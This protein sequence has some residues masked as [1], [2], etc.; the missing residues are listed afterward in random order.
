MKPVSDLKQILN[1]SI[2]FVVATLGFMFLRTGTDSSVSSSESD[3]ED[4]IGE[5]HQSSF[6]YNK[7]GKGQSA[8]DDKV[9][10]YMHEVQK[11][12]TVA[13]LRSL[14][15]LHG[16]GPQPKAPPKKI[17]DLETDPSKVSRNQQ[18]W[19][20][21]EQSQKDIIQRRIQEEEKLKQA[22]EQAKRQYASEFI[23]N[24]R[25]NGYHITLSP[26][27]EVL[28]VE[29]IKNPGQDYDSLDQKD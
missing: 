29:P 26:S 6:A 23:E 1:L 21:A 5:A 3:I 19:K 11:K 8:L 27:M 12:L 28:S 25:R 22:T 18:I 20:E 16:L 14:N 17:E 9:N 10:E 7:H 24:A 4:S 13:E 2:L 15:Q